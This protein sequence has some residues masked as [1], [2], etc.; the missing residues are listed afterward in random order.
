MNHGARGWE[1]RGPGR[2]VLPVLPAGAG[3]HRIPG[4]GRVGRPGRAHRRS[5]GRRAGAAR[6]GGGRRP[7]R[8]LSERA[9]TRATLAYAGFYLLDYLWL[10]RTLLGAT[11]HLA[12]FLAVVKILTAR[13]NRDYL[14]MAAIA[15]LELLAAA[16]VSVGFELLRVLWPWS[17]CSPS[18]P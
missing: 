6:P 5:G 3:G 1:R 17:C 7:R 15:F 4:A 18:P 16:L 10:S 2:A 14:Y 12:F 8:E 11:V 9:A 13:S